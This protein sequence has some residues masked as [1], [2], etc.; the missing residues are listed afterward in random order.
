MNSKQ[1]KAEAKALKAAAAAAAAEARL[2]LDPPAE[3]T[4][5]EAN[6]ALAQVA[7]AENARE[8]AKKAAKKSPV[9]KKTADGRTALP[10]LPKSPGKKKP[11]KPCKCGCGSQTRAI[12]YPG[13]DSR[14]RGWILR[15]ERG[16]VK[17]SEIPD[18]ERQA[19]AAEIKLRRKVD[20]KSAAAGEGK[21]AEVASKPEATETVN[22]TVQ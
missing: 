19:V 12:W 5:A 9:V 2:G 11:L 17:L 13:H 16:Y 3:L 14:M 21:S 7:K 15:V 18:G 8:A 6:A 4:E 22:E 20:G 1:R 10:P